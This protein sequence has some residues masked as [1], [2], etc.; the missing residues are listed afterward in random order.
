M[1]GYQTV[2]QFAALIGFWGAFASHQIFPETSDTQWKI[3]VEIQ[4][5][6][7]ALL[8]LGTLL[9]PEAPR[10]WGEKG[11]WEKVEE[12]L[13]WLRGLPKEDGRVE[14]EV[15]VIKASIDAMAR[16]KYIHGGGFFKQLMQKDVRKRLSVGV[17]L[18]IAQNM[19]GLNALN[20]CECCGASAQEFT[21]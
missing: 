21:Y 5:V 11:Q 20:Y 7:G 9:I 6:P 14:E 16:A 17:G 1:S 8:L 13:S 10:F 12:T 15:N 2:L 3:P 18:M 19:V 4:L